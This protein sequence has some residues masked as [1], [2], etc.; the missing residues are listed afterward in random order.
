[1]TKNDGLPLARQRAK[2]SATSEAAQ[3]PDP[4]KEAGRTIPRFEIDSKGLY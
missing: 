4:R 1:V 2:E 3:A